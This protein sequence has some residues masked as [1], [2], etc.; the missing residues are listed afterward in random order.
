MAEEDKASKTEEPT[1]KKLEEAHKKGNVP[2]S[3][4]M[5]HMFALLA[6]MMILTTT[7][8]WFLVSVFDE[9]RGFLDNM[10]DIPMDGMGLLNY[11]EGFGGSIV[12]LLIVPISIIIVFALGGA[13]L[14]HKPVFTAEKLMPKLEKISPMKGAKKI[15][16]MQ[17]VV[18]LVKTIIK[19]SLIAAIAFAIVWP[20]KEKLELLITAPPDL[21]L[22]LINEM[23]IQIVGVVLGLMFVIS[24]G[25]FAYQKYQHVQ[26]LRMTKQE[27]KDEHKQ[28]EGD[29]LIKGKIR[30]LRME[31]SRQRMLSSVPN[32][33]VVVTNPTHYAVA[34]EYKHGKMDVPVVVAKGVDFLAAKIREAADEHDVPIVENPPLARSLYAAV[35]IDEEV[36]PEHFKAVAGVISYVMKLSKKRGRR[37][38]S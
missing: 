14:Q 36:H 1:A 13:V 32:A 25:D 9:L 7:M 5:K 6:L 19:F 20:E 4:E 31:K 8:Q 2:K 30:Q 28:M 21:L 37:K 12:L 29:P 24:V 23:V 15:F 11:M 17:Q 35:E 3:Q 27:V 26:N 34:I 16:S 18:E 22:E 33:D 38:K 10:A